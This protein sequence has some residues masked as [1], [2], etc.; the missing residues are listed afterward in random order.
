[1]WR[2]NCALTEIYTIRWI[3]TIDILIDF[4][5]NEKKYAPKHFINRMFVNRNFYYLM[6]RVEK[7]YFFCGEIFKSSFELHEMDLILYNIL[8]LLEMC[9]V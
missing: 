4:F 6:V 7:I 2:E 8:L 1:M 9:V 3:G 5:N